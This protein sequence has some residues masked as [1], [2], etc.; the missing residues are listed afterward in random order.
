MLKTR[1]PKGMR[2][3]EEGQNIRY[4]YTYTF[5]SSQQRYN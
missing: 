1:Q 2:T 5:T 4:V 3:E